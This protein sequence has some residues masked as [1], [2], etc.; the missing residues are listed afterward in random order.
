MSDVLSN[1]R[2]LAAYRERTKGSARLAANA[3][4]LFPSGITHDSRYLEPYGV[5]VARAEG[6][7]KWDVDGNEYVDYFGG[8]GALMLGHS[9]PEVSR[10]AHAALDEGTH[11]GASH[12][13]EVRWA[14][15]VQE[16]IPSAARLRFTSSGT[17]AT[18]MAMRLARAFTS[19]RKIAR[20]RTNF[21]GWHDHVTSGFSSHFDG[22]PTAG[23]LPQVAEQVVLLPPGDL[24]AAEAALAADDDIAA[25]ILEPTGGLFGKVPVAPAFVARLRE[26]ATRH[27]VL[28]IFDEVV[29]GFRVSPGGF[30]GHHGI[31]PDLTT[32]AKILAGGL[33][34]GAVVGREDVL[35]ALD[36]NDDRRG[37]RE[38]IQHQ[39][40][41]NAN[42][43]SAAAGIATLEIVKD[44]EPGERA[45]AHGEQLRAELNAVL[46]EEAVPWAVYGEFS[47]FHIFTNPRHRSITPAQFSPEDCSYEELF[48]KGGDIVHKLRLAMLVNGVDLN[49]NPGGIISAAHGEA[50]LMQTVAAFRE[51]LRLLKR[52][53]LI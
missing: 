24:A 44:G 40:T 11:F 37:S 53:A 22:A 18:H 33:P 2:I 15:L 42:P 43:V 21:H 20:F 36:F 23:V 50:E 10:A 19:R 5:Y 48:E 26:L 12:E 38:K 1:S 31:I 41:F 46:R 16:L 25:V 30:Q 6:P 49:G 14:R 4:L 7:R 32:L 45:N 47:G 35:A 27:G 51:A 39:G 9:P 13:R 28:L 3:Q 17:E 29:T 34:G 8:H 52:E